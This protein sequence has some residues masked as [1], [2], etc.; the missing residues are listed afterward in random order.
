MLVCKF[1]VYLHLHVHPVVH[2]RTHSFVLVCKF[3]GKFAGPLHCAWAGLHVWP[4]FF[5]VMSA[6]G[7][8]VPGSGR[9]VAAA[10]RMFPPRLLRAATWALG[11]NIGM[12]LHLN[13]LRYILIFSLGLSSFS[14]SLPAV[15]VMRNARRFTFF[16]LKMSFMAFEPY[17]LRAVV[18]V[19][20]FI[21]VPI[22]ATVFRRGGM[23]NALLPAILNGIIGIGVH[24]GHWY[25]WQQARRWQQAKAA[26]CCEAGNSYREKQA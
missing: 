1:P 19:V 18:I 7:V 2:C 4:Y 9:L 17:D 26:A 11:P 6:Y 10:S 25:L 14:F 5:I 13:R 22:W 16:I 3:P 8:H 24:L 15:V 21:D 20:A 23:P 12:L